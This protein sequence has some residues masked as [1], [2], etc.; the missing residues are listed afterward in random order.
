M[1]VIVPPFL[2][3]WIRSAGLTCL[4]LHLTSSYTKKEDSERQRWRL[5]YEFQDI[6]SDTPTH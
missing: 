1:V 3:S 5:G 4:S 6:E 2:T